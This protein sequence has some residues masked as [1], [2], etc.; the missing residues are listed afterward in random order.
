MRA[1]S[2]RASLRAKAKIRSIAGAA[3]LAVFV[4][5]FAAGA[6][7]RGHAPQSATDEMHRVPPPNID[8]SL[9][10]HDPS[11]RTP[12]TLERAPSPTSEF[13]AAESEGP[14]VLVYP[15]ASTTEPHPVVV[16]LHG[17]CGA[18]EHECPALARAV[19]AKAFLVCPRAPNACANGGTRWGSSERSNL[20]EAVVDRVKHRFGDRIDDRERTLMGFSEGAF[21]ALAVGEHDARAWPRLA[22]IGAKVSPS[23]AL[24]KRH[25]VQRLLFAAGD[26]DLSHETMA[27]AA[28]QLRA[29][30]VDCAFSSLGKVGHRFAVDMDAWTRTALDWLDGRARPSLTASGAFASWPIPRSGRP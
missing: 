21:V 12:S 14:D 28:K 13:L 22:L 5:W 30:G 15:P 2:A 8:P 17:M 18:P 10:A 27:T 9:E 16:F 1:S 6:T 24:L 4:P 23:V 25:G 20:I 7:K 11:T 19:T 29:S 3:L 26:Y